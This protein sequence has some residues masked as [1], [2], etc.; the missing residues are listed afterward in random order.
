M[1][2]LP[3]GQLLILPPVPFRDG[4]LFQEISR[5]QTQGGPQLSFFGG[6]ARNDFEK[7]RRVSLLVFI[8]G[9]TPEFLLP[10]LLLDIALI[11]ELLKVPL[12]LA[13]IAPDPEVIGQVQPDHAGL[14]IHL[15]PWT[16]GEALEES[17]PEVKAG[18]GVLPHLR[19]AV[20][21]R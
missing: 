15:P 5:P 16:I 13:L 1:T 4:P 10:Q 17:S 7:K 8:P 21:R 20:F 18:A 12:Q 2:H 3:V 9:V 19:D 14:Y 6:N 11:V